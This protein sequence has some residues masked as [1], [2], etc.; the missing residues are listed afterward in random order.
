MSSWDSLLAH[1]PTPM[2]ALLTAQPS[3]LQLLESRPQ[4]SKVEVQSRGQCNDSQTG[5]QCHTPMGKRSE[6]HEYAG[7]PQARQSE[8]ST[9]GALKGAHKALVFMEEV[10]G[11]TAQ[12]RITTSSLFLI[13]QKEHLRKLNSWSPSKAGTQ[14]VSSQVPG[15]ARRT[16]GERQSLATLQSAL[17]VLRQSWSTMRFSDHRG[18]KPRNVHVTGNTMSANLTRSKTTG[19]RMVHMASC[20]FLVSPSLV[21][22]GKALLKS[23]SASSSL[24]LQWVLPER[25]LVRHWL[26]DAKP[27]LGFV[28]VRRTDLSDQID[29]IVLESS[30]RQVIPSQRHSGTGCAKGTEGLPRRVERARM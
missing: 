23:S 21:R 8:P 26:P 1:T 20:C 24:K 5:S 22:T 15:S 18:L 28:G 27:S 6:L 4:S 14:N 25:A 2:G 12:S 19:D 17:W 16:H 3:N 11:V 30:L 9:R 29:N 13:M 10:A 7:Y